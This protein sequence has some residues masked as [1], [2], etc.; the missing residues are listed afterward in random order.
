M[1]SHLTFLRLSK[2]SPVSAKRAEGYVTL[3]LGGVRSNILGAHLPDV[4]VTMPEDV[5]A[6]IVEALTDGD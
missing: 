5:A 3:E 2:G 1:S 4:S 6:A